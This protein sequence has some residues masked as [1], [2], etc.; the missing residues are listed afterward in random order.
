M[1]LMLF[2]F[3]LRTNPENARPPPPPK[4]LIF[5]YWIQKF[6]KKFVRYQKPKFHEKWD[7]NIKNSTKMGSKTAENP[8]DCASNPL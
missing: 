3:I 4:N 1:R 6:P 8:T 2:H 7:L 5:L